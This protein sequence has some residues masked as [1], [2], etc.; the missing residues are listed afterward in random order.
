MRIRRKDS[1]ADDR[2]FDLALTHVRRDPDPCSSL[3]YSHSACQQSRAD[4][5]QGQNQHNQQQ[6][7][8]QQSQRSL[9]NN[10]SSGRLHTTTAATPPL[11]PAGVAQAGPTPFWQANT[12]QQGPVHRQSFVA[13]TPV[14]GVSS[15]GIGGGVG[16][17]IYNDRAVSSPQHGRFTPTGMRSSG[18]RISRDGIGANM[19]SVFGQ[20]ATS[21]VMGPPTGDA[22]AGTGGLLAT[23]SRRNNTAGSGY[24]MGTPRR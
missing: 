14:R 15:G 9:F 23:P 19:P 13:P 7:Q 20:T 21:S 4:Q 22:G 8:Q 11:G 1:R 18:T 12:S 5:E 2:Q 24:V 6:Q 3:S 17:T 10:S 16:S